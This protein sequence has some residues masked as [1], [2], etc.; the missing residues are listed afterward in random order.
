[1]TTD[2]KK[3]WSSKQWKIKRAEY[4][5]GQV[6]Q[7]CGASENLVV[8]HDDYSLYNDEEAYLDLIYSAKVLCRSCNMAEMAGLVFCCTDPKTGKNH[9]R[10]KDAEYCP[11]CRPPE[12]V[13]RI[14]QRKASRLFKVRQIRNRDNARRRAFYQEMRART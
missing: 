7:F 3:I 12:E 1:M 6:C 9:Y 2:F 5:K 10:P 11:V 8:C 4:L 13:E 14:E